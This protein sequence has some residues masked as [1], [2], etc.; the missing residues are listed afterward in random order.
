MKN[1]L[2]YVLFLTTMYIGVQ[3]LLMGQFWILFVI[4]VFFFIVLINNNHKFYLLTN[5]KVER[6]I[7]SAVW[8]NDGKLYAGQP[9]NIETG[10]VVAG[11]RHHNC[12]ATAAA[13]AGLDNIIKLKMT[14]IERMMNKDDW[15]NHQGFL[16][17]HDRYVNR[18]EGLLIAKNVGQLL[19]D[20]NAN[21][22]ILFSEN[23]Y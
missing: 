19:D 15:K 23:L 2:F 4:N 8:Y 11:R 10:F 17:S 1:K 16:T 5:K 21:I 9:K 20:K 7:C 22:N 13:L 14:N 6:I 12:Y 3:L 18:K